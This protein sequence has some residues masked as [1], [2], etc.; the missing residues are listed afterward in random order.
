[1]RQHVLIVLVVQ[2]VGG[3]E[4]LHHRVVGA[5][6]RRAVSLQRGGER[7]VHVGGVAGR[8]AVPGEGGAVGAADTVRAGERDHV[9]G[10]EALG[11]EH[12]DELVEAAERR[13][14]VRQGLAGEGHV[15]VIA[16][17]GH[18][19]VDAAA[20]EEV[21]RVAGG[22]RDDVRARDLA[23]ACRLDLLLGRVDHLVA[24]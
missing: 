1:V 21:G 10:V 6:G 5:V 18:G 9:E 2:D 19:E 22:E 16:A 11:G 3:L 14:Q 4:V 20:A 15:A 12:L 17:G 13:G 7:R 23:R 8:E 24:P